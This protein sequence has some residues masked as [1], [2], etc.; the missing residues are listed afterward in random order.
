MGNG[1][2]GISREEAILIER[3][4]NNRSLSNNVSKSS[5]EE[6][7]ITRLSRSTKEK[8]NILLN[9]QEIATQNRIRQ[10]RRKTMSVLTREYFP[11]ITTDQFKSDFIDVTSFPVYVKIPGGGTAIAVAESIK[12]PVPSNSPSYDPNNRFFAV[13][14]AEP[15][16]ANDESDPIVYYR[17]PEYIKQKD[18][19]GNI[20]RRKIIEA[21]PLIVYKL[22]PLQQQAVL[23]SFA[24]IFITVDSD[25]L[26]NP[27]EQFI[28]KLKGSDV[29]T[30]V[31]YLK[32]DYPNI[33]QIQN[34]NK[35]TIDYKD[36]Q[37]IL[38]RKKEE[39]SHIYDEESGS[40]SI[41][42]QPQMTENDG[43]VNLSF[44]TL[45]D[46]DKTRKSFE[47]YSTLNDESNDKKSTLNE[48]TNFER[49]EKKPTPNNTEY[50][51]KITNSENVI[52]IGEQIFG[53]Q[54]ET[55]NKT[56]WDFIN[57]NNHKTWGNFQY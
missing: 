32:K 19:N 53:C 17:I 18:I 27:P 46:N 8:Q 36:Y 31:A 44:T 55:K 4:R 38:K 5:N 15:L 40:F 47:Y 7:R 21:T 56:E 57:I 42:N 2:S 11:K 23:A 39:E 22:F 28:G 29:E 37:N 52:P 10:P 26:R 35:R 43:Y 12:N 41:N 6:K 1:N 50:E 49:I 33:R 14:F 16:L 54:K 30:A 20:I 9:D 51:T 24:D 45:V 48:D 34:L 25:I 3:E 13:Q